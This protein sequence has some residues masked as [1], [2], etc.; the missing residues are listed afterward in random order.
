VKRFAIEALGKFGPDAKDGSPA[1]ANAPKEQA[2][3]VTS[4]EFSSRRTIPFQS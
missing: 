1:I 4:L 2:K 3:R